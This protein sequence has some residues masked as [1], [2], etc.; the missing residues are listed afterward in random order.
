MITIGLNLAR[1][2]IFL[3]L[4]VVY[5]IEV[6][7]FLGNEFSYFFTISQIALIPSY[8][9]FSLQPIQVSLLDK[10]TT[11]TI[12][13]YFQRILNKV[14]FASALLLALIS[15]SQSSPI[16]A[17]LL[18]LMPLT[19]YVHTNKSFLHLQ[20]KDIRSLFI[21][22]A[23][24]SFHKLFT[25]ALI[26][27]GCLQANSIVAVFVIYTAYN[28]SFISFAKAKSVGVTLQYI[29]SQLTG[30][31]LHLIAMNLLNIYSLQSMPLELSSQRGVLL[32]IG[33]VLRNAITSVFQLFIQRVLNFSR[34]AL[35]GLVILTTLTVG[36]LTILSWSGLTYFI[37]IP[38]TVNTF[39]LGLV[40]L[41]VAFDGSMV[42]IQIAQSN[43]Q[44]MVRQ[45]TVVQCW[46]LLMI[47]ILVFCFMGLIIPSA[48]DLPK[49]H[50]PSCD[51]PQ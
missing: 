18:G 38:N 27:L 14:A 16:N 42:P 3:L 28:L 43:K 7:S 19:T 2:G 30:V 29:F 41:T 10:H 22:N 34:H 1:Q 35:A 36:T 4:N 31:S 8:L 5:F 17:T 40:I 15:V 26:A 44:I 9:S 25:I 39:L 11:H 50:R 51:C 45:N 46:Y 13:I 49:A 23:K 47:A 24:E 12:I 48:I 32:Q 21:I 6:T 20:Q 37:D 33:M